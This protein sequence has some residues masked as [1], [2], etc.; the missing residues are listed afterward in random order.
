[1]DRAILRAVFAG[2]VPVSI[3]WHFPLLIKTVGVS[4]TK[5]RVEIRFPGLFRRM[6][7]VALAWSLAAVLPGLGLL[8][9]LD[10]LK[11][12]RDF[13]KT[14]PSL[15]GVVAAAWGLWGMF[16]AF[17]GFFLTFR[18]L[19]G[20][21]RKMEGL[22]WRQMR[23]KGCLSHEMSEV[24][25]E[26]FRALA[27]VRILFWGVLLLAGIL[28]VRFLL[29]GFILGSVVV[30]TGYLFLLAAVEWQTATTRL[31]HRYQWGM[32]FAFIYLCWVIM[33]CAPSVNWILH[34]L[35]LR[36]SGTGRHEV[37]SA[38]AAGLGTLPVLYVQGF[39]FVFLVATFPRFLD[40]ARKERAREFF[41]PPDMHYEEQTLLRPS[42]RWGS[43]SLR[44]KVS[45]HI[46]FFTSTVLGY[47]AIFFPLALFLRAFGV[48]SPETPVL[49]REMPLTLL[50]DGIQGKVLTAVVA[51]LM[52][53]PLA[54][55]SVA[56]VRSVVRRLRR[57]SIARRCASPWRES[58]LP[59]AP[60]RELEA[61]LTAERLSVVCV[62]APGLSVQTFRTTLWRQHYLLVVPVTA[63]NQLSD[64]EMEAMLWHECAH[65]ASVKAE[66]RRAV[67]RLLAPWSAG[68]LDLA[69]DFYESERRADAYAAG[70][71][72]TCD[73]L[74]SVLRKLARQ[75]E[76]FP[77]GRRRNRLPVARRTLSWHLMIAIWEIPR[78]GYLHPDTLQRIRW[79]QALRVDGGGRGS[80][81]SAGPV[82]NPSVRQPPR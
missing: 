47:T 54:L 2:R 21:V 30:L 29:E 19:E 28:T 35:S 78:A 18:V 79:L 3:L 41:L 24:G 4:R 48:V 32:R 80:T 23:R 71:M 42:E 39:F 73:P 12:F 52:G 77:S 7:I 33:A 63:Q 38:A 65:A 15:L 67:L 68:F 26:Y 55:A 25:E 49:G 58:G 14:E 59:Q 61:A 46:L 64:P 44:A 27:F 69:Y 76:A 8:L 50:S 37:V 66:S 10:T 57:L 1:M 45:A 31:F 62:P 72:G 43:T 40:R 34:A 11:T 20:H 51:S 16:C 36:A 6:L 5:T 9:L 56:Q 13:L 60:L 70:M 17:G 82:A 53:F 81:R 74:Q 22:I 75:E